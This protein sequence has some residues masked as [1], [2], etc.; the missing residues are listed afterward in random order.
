MPCQYDEH[1]WNL[2]ATAAHDL[3]I[4]WAQ[5]GQE[6]LSGIFLCASDIP[7]RRI[8]HC[9]TTTL[10]SNQRGSITP[11]SSSNHFFQTLSM[12]S[13]DLRC[14]RLN[15]EHPEQWQQTA[16]LSVRYV[17]LRM[18]KWPPTNQHQQISYSTQQEAKRGSQKFADSPSFNGYTCVE[19]LTVQGEELRDE[20]FTVS[21]AW[22]VVYAHFLHA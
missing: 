10:T 6:R 14:W 16:A 12:V 9:K 20:G 17:C 1:L 21:G 11:F 7:W 3:V 8:P 15:L 13:K 22:G 2:E 4:R 18:K 5:G 19:H